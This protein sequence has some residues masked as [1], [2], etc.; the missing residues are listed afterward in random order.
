VRG[1][2][3]SGKIRSLALDATAPGSEE[4]RSGSSTGRMALMRSVKDFIV[5]S[6]RGGLRLGYM[7]KLSRRLALDDQ[8]RLLSAD[9]LVTDERGW[10]RIFQNAALYERPGVSLTL[11]LTKA[12]ACHHRSRVRQKR[13][14]GRLAIYQA[15]N[16]P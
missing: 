13:R 4:L 7:F 11:Q 2:A 16:V 6:R 5:Y 14:T 12:R 15:R 10:A 1:F 9:G 3:Q 8:L